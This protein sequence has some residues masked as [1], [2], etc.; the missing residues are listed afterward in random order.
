MSDAPKAH[1]QFLTEFPAVAEAYQRLGAAAHASGPLDQR[2]RQLVKLALAVGAGHEGAVHAHTKKALA[3]GLSPAE[4]K[5]V[6][7]LAVTTVG[8]PNAVAAYT[9]VNDILE[10]PAAQPPA[11]A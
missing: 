5:Q 3:A 4:I 7:T 9:W 6:V 11:A 8:L 2:A 10:A 1:H